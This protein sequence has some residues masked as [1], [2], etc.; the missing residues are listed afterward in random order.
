MNKIIYCLGNYAL[1]DEIHMHRNVLLDLLDQN[2][3][4][5]DIIICCLSDRSFLYSNIFKNLIFYEDILDPNNINYITDNK[6]NIDYNFINNFDV[7]FSI[8]E[9]WNK[10]GYRDVLNQNIFITKKNIFNFNK[11]NYY[12]NNNYSENFIKLVKNISYLKNL[13]FFSD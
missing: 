10:Y 8:W 4:S 13:P 9:I 5:D 6:L 12:N 3:I 7:C 1:G 2:L 11:I